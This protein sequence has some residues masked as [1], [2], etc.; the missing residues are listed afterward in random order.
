M[1]SR[2]DYW[3]GPAGVPLPS[4]S[5]AIADRRAL[6]SRL[7]QLQK[8]RVF[9]GSSTKLGLVLSFRCRRRK[10]SGGG[11]LPSFWVRKARGGGHSSA[12]V[13]GCGTDER[14]RA[15]CSASSGIV[16]CIRRENVRRIKS[17]Y[18]AYDINPNAVFC[19]YVDV[20]RKSERRILPVF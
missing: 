1:L 10:R 13:A 6:L 17:V 11:V 8:N 16:F 4:P 19:P 3:V 12:V 7:V 18:W 9:C 14:C 2:K 5:P 15:S 20:R